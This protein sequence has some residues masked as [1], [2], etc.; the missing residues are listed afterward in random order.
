[1]RLAIVSSSFFPEPNGVSVS[2]YNRLRIYS[3]LGL[4]VLVF[5]P[6]YS[7]D[8]RYSTD[9]KIIGEIF[10]NVQ[11]KTFSSRQ[12]S[13]TPIVEP[14]FFYYIEMEKEINM[15]M[16]DII[17]IEE[18][19]RFVTN[20]FHWPFKNA[21]Q[22]YKVLRTALM[23]TLNIPYLKMRSRKSLRAFIWTL[24]S[25][26]SKL[27]LQII[28]NSYDNVLVCNDSS[29]NY[30]SKLKVNNL[31]KVCFNGV[32]DIFLKNCE[33]CR[34]EIDDT[35]HILYVGRL[36]P[37]KNIDQLL[38]VFEIVYGKNKNI[39]ISLV[40]K[41]EKLDRFYRWADKFPQ[42]V[43]KI[44]GHVEHQ[45]LP[46]IYKKHHLFVTCA[47]EEVFGLVILEAMASGLPV[48]GPNRKGIGELIIHGQN[49]F[50]VEP[51]FLLNYAEAILSL[52]ENR[53]LR[54]SMGHNAYACAKEFTWENAAKRTVNFW[55]KTYKNKFGIFLD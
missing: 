16:P 5:I 47:T 18:P 31:S 39:T 42:G 55:R 44:L 15:F 25:K 34:R 20:S 54:R 40:G 35:T 26:I 21:P 3:E 46:E 32:D 41:A 23:H 4:E 28:Y 7:C 27:Y 17:H 11:V 9:K 30:L 48:V 43:V 38:K 33:E 10:K 49:G 22:G 50:K 19:E 8:P 6:D 1:M 13:M 52:I 24:F 29:Y 51:N 2:L 12:S 45:K 14:S 36:Q 53:D 37:E